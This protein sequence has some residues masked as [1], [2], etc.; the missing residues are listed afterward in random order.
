MSEVTPGLEEGGAV[1]MNTETV[2]ASGGLAMRQ[3]G[4]TVALWV[5]LLLLLPV[6]L[7]TRMVQ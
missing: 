6:A 5:L 4:W 1:G 7:A 3:K 2:T